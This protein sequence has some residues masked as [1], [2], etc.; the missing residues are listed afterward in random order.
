MS[1]S[2]GSGDYNAL[3][4]AVLTHAIGDGWTTTG[5]TWPIQN[6]LGVFFNWNSATENFTNLTNGVSAPL[7]HRYFN[8][9]I[10]STV[11]EA[12]P[13]G[14]VDPTV[15]PNMNFLFTAWH[16]FSDPDNGEYIHVVVQ[17]SN[18]YDADCF[19]HFSFGQIDKC[20][21][22][23]S[24]ISYVT[25]TYKRAWIATGD[26]GYYGDSGNNIRFG[27]YMFSG[28]VGTSANEWANINH[29]IAPG[30]N[31]PFPNGVGGWPATGAVIKR[32][33]S[34]WAMTGG[35]A[36]TTYRDIGEDDYSIDA[37]P[38]FAKPTPF[39]NVLT[40]AAMY[41][42]FINGSG[43]TNRLR[44]AGAAPGI[45]KC[46]IL[47]LNPGDEVIYGN[48]TW[49]VFPVLKKTAIS[50]M[51]QQYKISS[52]PLAYAYKKVA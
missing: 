9:T 43:F 16:I 44:V 49:K 14:Y 47:G 8:L 19:G 51:S 10:G 21:L 50:D 5:G 23:H 3:M 52:G 17:F 28:L 35:Y 36:G 45:R 37:F 26:Y 33:A 27:S 11:A 4:A 31:A 32:G 34:S 15:V 42:I 30:A 13:V 18:G 38:W 22:D 41:Q 48:E 12:N 20:G 46:S 39:S 6:S 40:L 24:G 7:V 29:I 1:Y 2:T 25:A